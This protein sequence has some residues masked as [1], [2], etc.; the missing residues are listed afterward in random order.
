MGPLQLKAFKYLFVSYNEKVYG[1]NKAYFRSYLVKNIVASSA[2]IIKFDKL[3]QYIC[4][5]IIVL[6]LTWKGNNIFNVP[7]VK[8][9]FKPF[10][11]L[12]ESFK[13]CQMA[14]LFYKKNST[15]R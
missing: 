13:K 2:Y 1:A 7:K 5:I 14:T 6:K 11:G 12:T 9:M 15:T 3:L 10:W 4:I 8:K